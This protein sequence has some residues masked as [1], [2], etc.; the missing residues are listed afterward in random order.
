MSFNLSSTITLQQYREIEPTLTRP[1][2]LGG[3]RKRATI[4]LSGEIRA[5]GLSEVS[6]RSGRRS[7]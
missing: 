1:L 4:D 7:W 3:V 5:A 6:L 2:S